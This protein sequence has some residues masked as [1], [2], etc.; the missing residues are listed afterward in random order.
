MSYLST[1]AFG[2]L[3]DRF[4]EISSIRVMCGSL[5]ILFS[6]I[7]FWIFEN[8]LYINTLLILGILIGVALIIW[9]VL[10]HLKRKNEL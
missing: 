6:G 3:L 4:I 5:L 7:T 9:K 1:K 8:V 10:D 2:M